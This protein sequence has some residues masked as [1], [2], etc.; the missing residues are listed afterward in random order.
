MSCVHQEEDSKWPC[1]RAHPVT[2]P[3]SLPL[4]PQGA[5]HPHS[6]TSRDQ[7]PLFRTSVFILPLMVAQPSEEG[8]A[9]PSTDPQTSPLFAV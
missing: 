8:G 7:G 3:V 2:K 4:K 9:Y 5:D 6:V 1:P